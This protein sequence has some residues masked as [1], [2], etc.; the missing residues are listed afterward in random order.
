MRALPFIVTATLLSSV[1]PSVRA[2]P[3]TYQL[4]PTHTF[5][6]L[7]RR[8]YGFSNPI[9]VAV[10]DKGT[11]IFDDKDPSKSSVQVTLPIAKLDTFVPQLN[12]EFQ[13]AMFFDAGKFPT[14]VYK[15]K[16]VR[17]LGGGKYTII[18]D[19]TAHGVT[20]PVVLQ[21]TLNK[22]GYNPVS[23][24]QA[25]GFDATATLKRSDFGMNF[26]VPDVSDEITLKITT[27][28]DAAK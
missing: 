10:I 1:A 20:R 12:I 28:A 6:V 14:A 9:V 25:I 21:A 15:S 22:A 26:N 3:V 16:R 18:G 23:R 5:V 27:Q 7:S 13:S 24:A 11:L 4:D 8:N 19:L 2:A 17:S